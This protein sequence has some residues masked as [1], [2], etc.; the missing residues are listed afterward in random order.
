[1]ETVRAAVATVYET[2]L[3]TGHAIEDAKLEQGAAYRDQL[4]PFVL[5][6]QG[7]AEAEGCQRGVCGEGEQ[8]VAEHAQGDLRVCALQDRAGQ[9]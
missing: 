8:A 3:I 9:A 4:P 1:M 6:L 2:L 5:C 7:E